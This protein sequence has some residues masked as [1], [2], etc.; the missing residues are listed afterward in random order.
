[1]LEFFV[2]GYLVTAAADLTISHFLGYD[3]NDES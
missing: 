1:M 3:Q 2:V